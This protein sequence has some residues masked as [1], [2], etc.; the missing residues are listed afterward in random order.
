[1]AAF[2]ATEP[3]GAEQVGFSTSPVAGG[4]D[5][6]VHADFQMEAVILGIRTDAG[7]AAGCS[8]V[9]DDARASAAA[10]RAVQLTDFGSFAREPTPGF[11]DFL[12]IQA[13]N[14]ADF[15]LNTPQEASDFDQGWKLGT[16]LTTEDV[17]TPFVSAAELEPAA[18]TGIVFGFDGDASRAG[19][20][21]DFSE[22]GNDYR[23]D[24]V[25][26]PGPLAAFGAL[27][28]LWALRRRSRRGSG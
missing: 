26:E 28:A 20:P 27:A 17:L 23:A 25:P 5:V 12:V 7:C 8:F 21:V 16:L 15:A 14:D 19:T 18:G 6:F 24:P 13:V 2:A 1:M 10:G 3:S 22:A 11:H 9:F 4:F